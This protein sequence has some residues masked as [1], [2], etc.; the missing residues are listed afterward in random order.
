[1]KKLL[2]MIITVSSTVVFGQGF[3]QNSNIK[4]TDFSANTIKLKVSK[5]LKVDSIFLYGGGVLQSLVTQQSDL[6]ATPSGSLGLSFQT[7][8]IVFNLFYS[9]NTRSTL[10]I[11]SLYKFGSALLQSNVKGQSMTIKGYGIVT[12]RFGISYAA[13]ISDDF[14]KMNDSTTVDAS[15]FMCSF[16]IRYTPFDFSSIKAADL[17]FFVD[18]SYTHRSIFGDF[19]N[20]PYYVGDQ[21]LNQGGY[22][23][24]DISANFKINNLELFT[25]I[26]VNPV[27]KYTV[28]SFSGTQVIFGLNLTGKV[29][30][31]K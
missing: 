8:R 17:N 19:K 27:D 28:P 26:L 13:S 6:T 1:M 9:Y 15:P 31:L 20:R 2:L 29:V 4:Y 3:V 30:T 22:N 24:F 16:G 21:V 12:E 25:K 14:W 10:E 5:A 11:D 18:A 23:G 7:P